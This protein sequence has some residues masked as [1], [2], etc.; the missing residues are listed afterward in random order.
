MP[1]TRMRPGKLMMLF[2]CL[3][4]LITPFMPRM[5]DDASAQWSAPS[6]VYFQETGHSLDQ[7]FL[8]VW[9]SNNGAANYGYPITPEITL[10]NGHI[11]Q[12]LQY[13]RFE[14]WPE[15][16]ANG[17]HFVLG[18]VGEE[19]RPAMLQRSL[20]AGN[21]GSAAGVNDLVK[22]W[23]PVSADS[24]LAQ[25]AEVTYV[26]ATG[27]TVFGGFRDWWWATGDV[28]FLG[29]PIS[30]EYTIGEAKYQAFEYGQL[31]WTAENGVQLSPIGS[32]LAAKYGL[33]TA[34]VAQGDIPSYDEALFIPPPT[35]APVQAGYQPGAGEVWVDINLSS[36]YMVVYQGN[37][38]LLE[39]Y[40]SSGKD[41]WETPTG[42]FYVL[43]MYTSHTMVG[44]VAGESWYVP[45]VPDVLYFTNQG[46]AIHGTYWHNSFGTRLSHG[47][48]NMPEWAAD[49]LYSIAFVGMRIEIHY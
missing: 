3:A 49:Y 36:Q 21:S 1:A 41:G 43:T 47:C 9:R 7:V 14:Y 28:N 35:E 19:L 24:D 27:H 11:V 30:Q 42:T 10:E 16:D 39:L 22:A 37:T 26:D 17:N 2:M 32:V 29:N 25:E 44:D 33:D 18:K 6:T 20:I 38:V 34:P 48:I 23:L 4:V 13:A 46:H 12:Y 31:K 8:D 15:G 40:I 45:D 5:A